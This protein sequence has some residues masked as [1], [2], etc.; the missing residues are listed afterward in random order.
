MLGVGELSEIGIHPLRG[1]NR[2]IVCGYGFGDKAINAYIIRWLYE[3]R[4]N[5]LIVVHPEPDRLVESARRAVGRHWDGWR[6]SGKVGTVERYVQDVGWDDVA[7][8]L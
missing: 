2:L 4:E 1:V 5:R 6:Q 7:R 3:S 8:V